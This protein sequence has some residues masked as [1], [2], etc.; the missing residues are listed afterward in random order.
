MPGSSGAFFAERYV[1]KLFA[2]GK[3]ASTILYV[4]EG[5][6]DG[7]EEESLEGVVSEVLPFNRRRQKVRKLSCSGVGRE[8][9]YLFP[10]STTGDSYIIVGQKGK[11][12]WIHVLW[13]RTKLPQVTV[14]CAEL[15]QNYKRKLKNLTLK[16]MNEQ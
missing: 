1:A 8:V 15:A 5:G 13:P 14:N 16:G 9:S 10:P 11:Q 2:R 12:I 4:G 6:K 3:P 7:T